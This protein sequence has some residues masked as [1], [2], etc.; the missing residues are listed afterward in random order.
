MYIYIEHKCL[1]VQNKS[2]Y[3]FSCIPYLSKHTV[4]TTIEK[5][6]KLMKNNIEIKKSITVSKYQKT[7]SL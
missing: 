3:L 2:I 7:H 1:L 5:K 6:D 4:P